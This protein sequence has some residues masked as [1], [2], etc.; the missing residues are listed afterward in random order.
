MDKEIAKILWLHAGLPIVPFISVRKLDW[1][2]ADKRKQ[3][4][5]RAERDFMYP[6]FV[7]P[8][9]AGSSVGASKA[10]DRPGLEQAVAEALLWDDKVLIEPFVPAR[11]VECSVTGNERPE[12]YTPGE[13][14]PTHEFYDYEAKYIDPDGAALLIPADLTEA[15]FRTIREIAIKAYKAAE[16][17]GLS[18]ID[19][20]VRKDTREILLN[21]VNT[22][23]GFTTISMFPKMCEASGLSYPD[24][25]DKLINLAQERHEQRNSRNY[26]YKNGKY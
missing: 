15:E 9:C 5:E 1:A 11:E 14:I 18:R 23:P 19:F 17:S 26:S 2:S 6:L 4:I 10:P 3:I 24:L 22:M 21:E 16:L 13:I 20:F 25:L 12:A 7:K 8:S